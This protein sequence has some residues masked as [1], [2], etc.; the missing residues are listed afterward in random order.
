LIFLPYQKLFPQNLHEKNSGR[1]KMN[2]LNFAQ[3]MKPQ[4]LL[5]DFFLLLV[6]QKL[7]PKNLDEKNLW[8]CLKP[9]FLRGFLVARRI[10]TEIRSKNLSDKNC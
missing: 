3:K 8:K 2:A 1:R 5:F 10:N 9:K 6:S 4:K 7:F